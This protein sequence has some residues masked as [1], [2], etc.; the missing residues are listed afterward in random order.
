MHLAHKS[1]SKILILCMIAIV[2]IASFAPAITYGAG[3][4]TTGSLIPDNF[5]TDLGTCITGLVYIIPALSADAAF[6]I[7]YVFDLIVK[8]SLSSSGYAIDFLSTGWQTALSIANMAFLFILIY[9]AITI[10][11]EAETGGT[12]RMLSMLIVMALLVN[13]SFLITRVVIDVGN[14]LG[15]EFYNVI[16]APAFE[17]EGGA[18]SNLTSVLGGIGGFSSAGTKDLTEPIMNEIGL[19]HMFDNTAFQS[20]KDKLGFSAFGTVTEIITLSTLFIAVAAAY[21][22][23]IFAFTTAGVKFLMR[24]IVLW[25][26][27]IL[28]PLAFAARA[29]SK[30]SSLYDRWQKALIEFSI[31]PAAFLFMFYILVETATNM[32]NGLKGDIATQ[33]FG[34]PNQGLF[35]GI[36]ALV[37]RLGIVMAMLFF[38]L[39]SVDVIAAEGNKFAHKIAGSVTGQVQKWS[40]MIPRAAVGVA[41]S[42]ANEVY[43]GSVGLGLQKV[44]EKFRLSSFGNTKLGHTIREKTTRAAMDKNVLGLESRNSFLN[45][46]YK[47]NVEENQNFR[48]AENKK[49]VTRVH[50]ALTNNQKVDQKDANRITNMKTKEIETLARMVTIDKPLQ[51]IAPIITKQQK[52]SSIEENDNIRKDTKEQVTSIWSNKSK[53]ALETKR[54]Q[55]DAQIEAQTEARKQR[56]KE[57]MQ[58]S[59]IRKDLHSKSLPIPEDIKEQWIKESQKWLAENEQWKNILPERAAVEQALANLPQQIKSN[60]VEA[61]INTGDKLLKK[62]DE[63][64]TT[65][66]LPLDKLPLEIKNGS[67]LTAKTVSDALSKSQSNVDGYKFALTQAKNSKDKEKTFAAKIDLDTAQQIHSALKNLEKTV[68]ETPTHISRLT[69]ETQEGQMDII[70]KKEA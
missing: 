29:L 1:Y 25:F 3:T 42:G 66:K 17:T 45:R 32:S 8:L 12:M 54:A 36:A 65:L 48:D 21:W 69:G 33:I 39:Q 64:Q 61:S 58:R 30:G 41:K 63:L 37:I 9:I 26:V 60:S 47:R 10:L 57:I 11:F 22:I 35:I 19:Q 23:L 40:T 34:N 20:W 55:L 59:L 56:S 7:A 16:S 6:I 43:H 27:L 38:G 2:V 52:K 70:K 51:T 50:E 53:E 4:Y 31:Y 15:I 67:R 18:A 46:T 44:D 24:T 14:I 62:L 5:C 68:R 49:A 28:A 13:F